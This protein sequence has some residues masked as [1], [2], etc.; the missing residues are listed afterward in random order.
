[1]DRRIRIRIGRVMDRLG[2]VEQL[3]PVQRPVRAGDQA[4]DEA[5]CGAPV[6]QHTTHP[7]QT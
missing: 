7:G 4:E 3:Q 1:M 6:R 5:V 2:P